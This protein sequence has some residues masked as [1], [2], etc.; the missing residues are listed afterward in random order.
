MELSSNGSARPLATICL[1]K[2]VDGVDISFF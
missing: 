1:I 2:S